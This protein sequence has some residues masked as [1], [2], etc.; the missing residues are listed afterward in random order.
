MSAARSS[1][2]RVPQPPLP[3]PT[4]PAARRRP[5]G[6]RTV[7]PPRR[8][9]DQRGVAPL[10]QRRRAVPDAGRQLEALGSQPLKVRLGQGNVGGGPLKLPRELHPTVSG[11]APGRRRSPRRPRRPETSRRRSAGRWCGRLDVAGHAVQ[12]GGQLLQPLGQDPPGRLPVGSTQKEGCTISKAGP[13]STPG[14]SGPSGRVV[15]RLPSGRITRSSG[16]WPSG[17]AP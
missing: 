17:P 11:K 3:A 15:G 13:A 9:G 12:V 2:S 4:R 7:G 10:G 1:W 14:R 16:A 6:P 5:S 8:L